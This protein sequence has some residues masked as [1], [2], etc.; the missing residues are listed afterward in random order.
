MS[1]AELIG[2][3][4]T[5]ADIFGRTILNGQIKSD[6]TVLELKNIDKGVYIICIN[7][8]IFKRLII[9]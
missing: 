3:D 6:N 5:I 1:P 7:N 9:K 8:S 2:M 4:Y